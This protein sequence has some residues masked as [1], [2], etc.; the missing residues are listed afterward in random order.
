MLLQR[1]QAVTNYAAMHATSRATC[2]ATKYN[3]RV[4]CPLTQRHRLQAAL[5]ESKK[6]TD[7]GLPSGQVQIEVLDA[8]SIR[9]GIT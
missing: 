1:M 2:S 6:H 5:L 9:R 3:T 4:S 8:S 7:Q